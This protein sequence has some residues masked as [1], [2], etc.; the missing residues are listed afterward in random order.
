VQ[1]AAIATHRFPTFVAAAGEPNV[2]EELLK[3]KTVGDKTFKTHLDGYD[4]GPYFR[5]EAKEGPRKE[6]FYFSDNAD[7]MAVRYNDWKLSFKTIKG[8]LFTGTEES[9]NVPIVV[10]LREDPFEKFPT[11]WLLYAR[12]WGEK[13]WT[14]VPANALAG[15]FLETFKEY[16][17][18]QA[19]GTFGIEQALKMIQAGTTGAGK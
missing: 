1:R 15:Q 12:W 6:I 4:F 10:N 3:G 11:E 5:G 18:S 16:P 9:T 2:K 17:P 13:L 19:S 7:L 14:L 8:N